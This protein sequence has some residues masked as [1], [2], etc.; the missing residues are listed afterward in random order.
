MHLLSIESEARSRSSV[1]VG[2]VVRRSGFVLVPVGFAGREPFTGT[3]LCGMI[4]CPAKMRRFVI[5]G[6]AE[7]V[8]AAV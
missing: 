6:R 5:G 2:I 4:M 3:A 7:A 1:A 8:T